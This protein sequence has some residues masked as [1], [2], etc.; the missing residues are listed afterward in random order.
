[1]RRIRIDRA[2][3]AARVTAPPVT[4]AATVTITGMTVTGSQV[5]GVNT[6]TQITV[7]DYTIANTTCGASLAPGRSCTFTINF[8]P[9][10]VGP[11]NGT[12]NIFEDEA[13]SPQAIILTGS[14]K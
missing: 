9:T 7:S 13:D 5:S 4:C 8:T 11:T 6:Y 3:V 2:R 12:L 14:G 1:M 10:I